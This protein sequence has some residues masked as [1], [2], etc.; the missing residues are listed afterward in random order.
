M[1][2]SFPPLPLL[3]LKLNHLYGCFWKTTGRWSF[4][5]H[6]ISPPTP[7]LSS[8][9]PPLFHCMFPFGDGFISPPRLSLMFFL[10]SF[11]PQTIC[12]RGGGADRRGTEICSASCTCLGLDLPIY[13]QT[14]AAGISEM[15]HQGN[16]Q[17][18]SLCGGPCEGILIDGY[19]CALKTL[20]CDWALLFH[21]CLFW[22][23]W[24]S[25][26][27]FKASLGQEWNKGS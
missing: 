25:R 24:D 23:A 14:W 2:F 17:G 12:W 1:L 18:P 11:L 27:V 21:P 10:T 19:G 13:R 22:T 8:T 15:S 26:A 4:L 3:S 9:T 6:I 7:P 5:V 20:C 16:R